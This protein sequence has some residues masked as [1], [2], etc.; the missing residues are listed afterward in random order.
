VC[1]AAKRSR[2]VATPRHYD[3]KTSGVGAGIKIY[4]QKDGNVSDGIR[5]ALKLA[6][7]K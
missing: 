7:K 4:A 5:K 1:L 2:D 3:G 6:S